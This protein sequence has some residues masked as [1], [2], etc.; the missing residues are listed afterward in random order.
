MRIRSIKPEFWQSESM[1]SL[2]PFCRLAAIA[3]L[4][5]SD[6]HGYF[7]A[8][9]AVVRG[10]VFP[11]EETLAN[12]SRALAELSRVGYIRI[13]T[14]ASGKRVGRVEN[15][16]VHQRVDHPSRLTFDV[17][18]IVWDGKTSEDSRDSR[19][20]L[21]SPRESLDKEHGAGSMEL[22]ACSGDQQAA[23]ERAQGRISESAWEPLQ[24]HRD[25]CS[26]RNADIDAQLA[27]FRERNNGQLDTDQGWAVRFTQWLGRS[28]PESRVSASA[29]DSPT[30]E[31]W[32]DEAAKLDA[33]AHRAKMPEWPASLAEALWHDQ[34]AKGWRYTSDWRSALVAA[35]KRFL[36]LEM[37]HTL[38]NQR[39]K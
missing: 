1:S 33:E 27:R 32:M 4:N 9:P 28:R 3:F 36:G 34:A 22:G 14:T 26:L 21:A 13:G 8:T 10:E 35:H 20:I 12:V 38:R 15:F 17:D 18:S 24:E 6:D 25:L 16:K 37:N 23:R 5:L 11:F 29:V 31:Q 2:D 7:N 19:E 30:L 39:R